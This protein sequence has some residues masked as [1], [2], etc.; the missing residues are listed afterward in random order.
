MA[1]FVWRNPLVGAKLQIAREWCNET[2]M[3][4]VKGRTDHFLLL[5]VL[6]V[7][8]WCTDQQRVAQQPAT[9]HALYIIWIEQIHDVR[10]FCLNILHI[11]WHNAIW[12]E[13]INSVGGFYL[14]RQRSVREIKIA[15]MTWW[16]HSSDDWGNFSL[17]LYYSLC[18]QTIGNSS[19][20]PER[21]QVNQ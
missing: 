8:Y 14:N 3:C 10:G 4:K 20:F 11:P 7:P 16:R 1:S 9:G 13:Q 17:T 5:D 6:N 2:D 12:I 18:Q 15:V 21:V 19:P